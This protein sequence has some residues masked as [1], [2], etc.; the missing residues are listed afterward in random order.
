[1][2]NFKARDRKPIWSIGHRNPQGLFYDK[3]T[4]KLYSSE[5][6]PEGGDEINII[7]RNANYGWP[8]ITYG[9]EY[10]THAAIGEGTVKA[11]ME[12]PLYYYDPSIATSGIMVYHGKMFPEFEN[13]IFVG[14]LAGQHL[15]HLVVEDGKVI[16]EER[17]L[18]DMHARVRDIKTARD[19]S[20]YVLLEKGI[21]LRLW[22][23]QENKT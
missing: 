18:R 8:V 17:W 15:N 7:K 10:Q 3:K 16:R 11:G 21:L 13:H 6:G 2:D 14:A 19:G 23:K 9:H 1:M 4:K 5:H 22:R 12:Q 20:I